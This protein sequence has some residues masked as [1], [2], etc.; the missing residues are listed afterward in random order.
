MHGETIPTATAN[1]RLHVYSDNEE[2]DVQNI[3][4]YLDYE[5]VTEDYTQSG[6]NGQGAL[7]NRCLP[8]TCENGVS[9]MVNERIQT[10]YC[11]SIKKVDAE[12]SNT[13]VSGSEW[14]LTN[15]NDSTEVHTATTGAN[16]IATF[17]GLKNANYILKE[18]SS[19]SGYWN[20][21]NAGIQVSASNL[22]EG[23]TCSVSQTVTDTK[24]YYCLKIKKVDE[25]GNTITSSNAKFKVEKGSTTVISDST[26]NTNAS[27]SNGITSFFFTEPG[28]YKITETGAP[29][30]Y[31][32]NSTSKNLDA[33]VL[34]EYASESA[35]RSACLNSNQSAESPNSTIA[36]ETYNAANSNY[37]FTNEQVVKVINWFKVSENGSTKLN[38]AKFKVKNS[39]NQYITVSAPE[40]TTDK[41]STPITK[42]CYRYTG[43]S[44]SGSDMESGKNGSTNISMTGEVCVSGLPEGTYTVEETKPADYHTFGS[45][46]T[47]SVSTSDKFSGMTVSNK[48]VNYET[49]FE[50]TKTVSS[51]GTGDWASITTEELQKI[52]FNV[53][54]SNNNVLSFVKTADGTYEFAGNDLDGTQG[55][56]VTDLFV[57]SN[58]KI[59]IKHLSVGTYSIKEKREC[60]DTS[61]N[62]CTGVSCS[63]YYYPK[64]TSESEYKFSIT[65]CS[66]AS[67]TSCTT[68]G[69][70]G[71]TL[72]N[73]PTEIT[74]TKSDIYSYVNPNSVVKFENEKK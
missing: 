65:T 63:G 26:N 28:T 45:S 38:R 74:F 20:D 43:T 29:T 41:S 57:G 53:I 1:S 3:S 7:P 32:L 37:V 10:E 35:A 69:V 31:N 34:K 40:S 54:D 12:S 13:P 61:C 8:A 58:R 73:K 27:T 21:N 9:G 49:V 51:G 39:S 60:C 47:I 59:V 11:Y 4:F 56:A 25:T 18:T 64:Y 6:S 68:S 55:N 2:V 24:K 30:G 17:T 33:K 16:G 22:T 71:K 48:L 50:F 42:A 36:A 66:N 72:Q 62:S 5:P 52:P 44:S 67:A 19:P 14:T 46:K 70:V 23:S 15:A